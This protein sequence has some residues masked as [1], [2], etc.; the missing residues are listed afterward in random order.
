MDH[1]DEQLIE[2]LSADGRASTAALART[3]GLSRS[4]VQDRIARLEERNIIAG[5]TIRLHAE[6]Q[7]QQIA[8]HVLM[9]VTQS[10]AA[11]VIVTLKKHPFIKALHVV[12]GV[13]DMIAIIKCPTMDQ[14]DKTLDD[15]NALEGVEKTTTSLVL[16]TKLDR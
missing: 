16:T 11:Q 1:T 7:R 10:H 8:A 15:I 2:L 4:T 14:I 6:Y 5:Y 12:S 9:A 3:L 13:Y